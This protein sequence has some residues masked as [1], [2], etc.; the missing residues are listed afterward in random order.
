[1]NIYQS[2]SAIRK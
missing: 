1:M 2:T